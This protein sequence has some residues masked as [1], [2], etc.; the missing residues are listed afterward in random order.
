M[1]FEIK[2]TNNLSTLIEAAKAFMSDN[3]TTINGKT[4]NSYYEGSSFPAAVQN[5]G[6]ETQKL[7][8]AMSIVEQDVK[9]KADIK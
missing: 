9:H 6:T 1:N 5:S 3:A 2:N 8:H 4:I 7:A